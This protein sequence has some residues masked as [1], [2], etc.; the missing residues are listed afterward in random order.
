M[1]WGGNADWE[2]LHRGTIVLKCLISSFILLYLLTFKE[3]SR[4][5]YLL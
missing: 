3:T 4:D 1:W 2:V 5:F